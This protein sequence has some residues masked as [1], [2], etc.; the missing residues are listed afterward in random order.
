[1]AKHG[2]ALVIP[3][4]FVALIWY[5]MME[6][7]SAKADDGGEDLSTTLVHMEFLAL[8]STIGAT[9]VAEHIMVRCHWGR[10][11]GVDLKGTTPSLV[12]L[13]RDFTACLSLP[14]SS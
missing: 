11:I 1:M 6:R 12:S 8:W 13:C 4:N 2:I 5:V 3:V 14:P 9:I 7:S 10:M